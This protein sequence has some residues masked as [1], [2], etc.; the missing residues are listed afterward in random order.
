[1]AP[2]AE[3]LSRARR[4]SALTLR[5]SEAIGACPSLH[6]ALRDICSSLPGKLAIYTWAGGRAV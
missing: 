3:S 2:E 4:S 1:M 5:L 6:P